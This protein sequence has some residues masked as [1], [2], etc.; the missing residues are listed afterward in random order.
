MRGSLLVALSLAV[1]CSTS[2]PMSALAQ[3]PDSPQARMAR[4]ERIVFGASRGGKP[5]A[6]RLN[7]LE[8]FIFGKTGKGGVALRLDAVGKVLDADSA[9]KQ[10]PPTAP[11]RNQSPA[12]PR[13]DRPR[14]RMQG[15][16]DV[17]VREP[18]EVNRLLK[19]GMDL[20]T[21]GR[22]DEAEHV[23]K[24]VLAAD[25]ENANALYNLGAL[26]ERHGDM[27]GALRFYRLSLSANPADQQLQG[28]VD[29]LGHEVSL[30][31]AA[32]ARADAEREF[33]LA[34]DGAR[35]EKVPRRHG[36]AQY[37]ST[38]PYAQTERPIVARTE[39]RG[40]GRRSFARVF[41]GVALTVGASYAAP[42]LHCPLCRMIGGF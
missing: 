29:E 39:K 5:L 30:R 15:H 1:L 26:T 28:V 6:Q 33:A 2:V 13:S 20:Y 17:S 34:A 40:G 42:G 19:Q 12:D 10:G 3:Q 8:E 25:A 14:E 37:A 36:G 9:D 24:Q 38:A 18:E 11:E 4:Y 27:E 7:A 32:E 23:F 41:A 16:V 31:Q 22:F 21:Q 35:H